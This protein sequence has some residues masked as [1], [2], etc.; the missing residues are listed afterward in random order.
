MER[1]QPTLHLFD[2]KIVKEKERLELLAKSLKPGP[3]RDR[4]LNKIS[5]LDTAAHINEWLSSPGLQ[6]PL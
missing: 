3:E 4:L 6:K 5:Q 1:P 2:D